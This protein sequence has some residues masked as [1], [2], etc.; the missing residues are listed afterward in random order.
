MTR[1]RIGRWP[2]GRTPSS[3]HGGT[4]QPGSGDRPRLDDLIA[5]RDTG[6]SMRLR[7][8]IS[9]I[10][11]A[12]PTLRS[13][14]LAQR[15]SNTM[16]SSGK[17]NLLRALQFL[18]RVPP[19]E[20]VLK[21]LITHPVFSLP[22]D[23]MT[24]DIG[25]AQQFSESLRLLNSQA[26][27]LHDALNVAL[28][29]V[30]DNMIAFRIPPTNSLKSV[31]ETIGEIEQCLQQAVV[32]PKVGGLVAFVGVES[33]SAWL[34]I[35]VGV[36]A[37]A[38]VVKAIAYA[39]ALLAQERVRHAQAQAYIKTLGFTIDLM[40]AAKDKAKLAM[41]RLVT[42]KA[43]AIGAEHYDGSPEQI[44]RLTHV[45]STLS[46]LFFRGAAIEPAKLPPADTESGFPNVEKL[47]EAAGHPRLLVAENQAAEPKGS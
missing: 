30:D 23:E 38:V 15:S 32:H 14:Q 1:P 8:Q 6:A 28:Q 10:E 46:D 18:V 12:L 35:S 4:R 40:E 45:L 25:N 44:G 41:D 34:L 3:E 31:E 9:L 26:T 36:P 33:G 29:P 39:S 24:L 19:L 47:L 42:E 27:L 17:E 37:A 5:V 7:E 43:E 16:G 20:P 11:A 21:P 22:G 2:S 13:F